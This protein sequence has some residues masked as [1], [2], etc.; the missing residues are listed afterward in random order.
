MEPRPPSSRACV[1]R[2]L[3]KRCATLGALGL[4]FAAAACHTPP[5]IYE[6]QGGQRVA[7][8][9]EGRSQLD[10]GIVRAAVEKFAIELAMQPERKD[11]AD[12]AAEALRRRYRDMG[13]PEAKVSARILEREIRERPGKLLRFNIREGRRVRLERL[14]IQGNHSIATPDLMRLWDLLG[15][16]DGLGAPPYVQRRI[17]GFVARVLTTYR[18]KGYLDVRVE[19]Q[20]AIRNEA[21]DSVEYVI[22]LREGPLYSI[23]K[24]TIDER[25]TAALGEIAHGLSDKPLD[26]SQV[27]ALRRSLIRRLRER[28]HSDPALRAIAAQDKKASAVEIELK[29][30]PGEIRT[31]GEIVVR[32]RRRVR[33]SWIRKRI[34][35][36][37]GDRLRRQPRGRER[38][39]ARRERQVSRRAH[40]ARGPCP[41]AGCGSSSTCK[42]ATARASTCRSATRATNAFASGCASSNRKPFGSG[43]DLAFDTNLDVKGWNTALR[44]SE[45][46]LAEAFGLEVQVDYGR[47]RWPGYRDHEFGAQAA[48]AFELGTALD[49]RV[50]YRFEDHNGSSYEALDASQAE[51]RAGRAFAA[52]VLDERVMEAPQSS[53]LNFNPSGARIGRTIGGH[54]LAL[55]GNWADEALGGNV[56]LGILRAARRTLVARRG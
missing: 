9:F 40:A 5:A 12:A 22:V 53:P 34:Q 54:R 47:R 55:E 33:E 13:F 19:K 49:L 41:T 45:P 10:E 29:G 42:N 39:R 8:E 38:R 44:L 52:L 32:G 3:P 1:S 11:L 46:E 56:S 23:R 14:E 20:E 28:G 4:L 51:Y 36:A 2:E 37:V 15:I 30:D 31:V 50:G 43:P 7:L 26:M 18:N 16:D 27:D 25:V 35:L 48:L 21:G 6:S 24:L 17:D